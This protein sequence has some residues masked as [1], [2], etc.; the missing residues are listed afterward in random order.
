[1]KKLNV[2]VDHVATLRQ[3]RLIDYPD[4]IDVIK[5]V[6]KSKAN[7]VVM[8]L[9]ED[10]RHIQ[11]GD[12][13]NFRKKIKFHFNLEIAPTIE[14]I[15]I[16]NKIRPDVI[17]LVPEKRMEL[18]TE[19]GLD[20]LKNKSKINKVLSIL[21]PKIKSMLFIDPDIKILDICKELKIYGVEINTGS[22]CEAKKIHIKK[23]VQKI[24][25]ASKYAKELGYFVAAGHG[26]NKY[27]IS[28]IKNI[29]EIEEYNIG[30]SII[31]DSIFNGI[32]KATNKIY[33]IINKR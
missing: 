14:M 15:K 29:K 27:N 16:A 22:Y 2:N 17:T 11:D 26:L 12:L 24:K 10:R 21:N 8:H 7:G 32:I 23:E 25:E 18:T 30:H 1:M 6:Q 4:P 19:G 33:D 9:R 20:L 31:S 3:A 13:L 5:L 28:K